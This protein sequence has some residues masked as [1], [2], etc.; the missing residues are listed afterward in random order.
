[1]AVPIRDE[2][3][4]RTI[5]QI[6]EMLARLVT[7][8][9]AQAISAPEFTEAGQELDSLYLANLGTTRSLIHRLGTEDL[10]DVMRSAGSVHA[11]RAYVLG[12]LLSTE[13][14]ILAA[15]A[16]ADSAEAYAMRS[17]ALDILL[18]AGAANLGEPD[19]QERVDQLVEHV[20]QSEWPTVRFE[21]LLR[22]EAERGEFA[23]AETA[24]FT[25]LERAASSE[26]RLQ[27]ADSANDYYALLEAL[28]DD[29]LEKGGFSRGEIGEGRAD[30]AE[31]FAELFS[32]GA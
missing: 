27:V 3:I 19:L 21:R 32:G 12:A 2:L 23:E 20:P 31:R 26:E 25:W 17:S 30:F 28:E 4:E 1:V 15:Y 9:T 6:A 16:G 7:D 5:Q 14:A 24:L 29:D 10:L 11:E 8:R 18:E 22:Y 13:A